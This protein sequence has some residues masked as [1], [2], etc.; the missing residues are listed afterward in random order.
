MSSKRPGFA[1]VDTD[2]AGD[3]PLKSLDK[4][5]ES[6]KG[7]DWRD[8]GT[9]EKGAKVGAEE[10]GGARDLPN[11]DV[12]EENHFGQGDVVTTVRSATRVG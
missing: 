2:H 10:I 6:S 12:E 5:G 11:F 8:D 3:I 7:Q 4:N 9:S 1:R